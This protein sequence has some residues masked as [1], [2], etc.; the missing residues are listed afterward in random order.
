[1]RGCNIKICEL[2]L[3]FFSEHPL[4]IFFLASKQLAVTANIKIKSYFFKEALTNHNLILGEFQ[5]AKW[6]KGN[7]LLSAS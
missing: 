7:P 2:I 1:M 6:K 3:C 5:G 4:L